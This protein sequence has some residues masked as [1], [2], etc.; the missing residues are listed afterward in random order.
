MQ[1]SCDSFASSQGHSWN[2]AS[3]EKIPMNITIQRKLSLAACLIAGIIAVFWHA[4]S[5]AAA[6][7]ADSRATAISPAKPDAHV[8]NAWDQKTAAAYLDQRAGWW[9]GWQRAARDHDTFCVSCHTAVP[10]AMS[11][12][13]LRTALGEPGLSANEQKLIDNVTKRVRLWKEV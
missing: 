10:Y 4:E 7:S 6:N 2:C 8:A 1:A 13:S 3:R 9:M 11:R 5:R 12:P